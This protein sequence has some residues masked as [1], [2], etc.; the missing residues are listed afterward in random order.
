MIADT[1]L[2]RYAEEEVC[3]LSA[4]AHKRYT[5]FSQ[6]SI[7]FRVDAD[8]FKNAHGVD[9]DFFRNGLINMRFQK[10]PDTCGRSLRSRKFQITKLCKEN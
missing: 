3:D 5:S 2:I 8:F 6:I 7:R 1:E 4:H 9:A 10:Y